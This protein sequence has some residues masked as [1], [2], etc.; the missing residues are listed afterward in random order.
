M[1]RKIGRGHTTVRDGKIIVYDTTVLEL[2]EDGE[3]AILRAGKWRTQFTCRRIN[4]A[5]DQFNFTFRVCLRKGSMF[6]YNYRTNEEWDF[7]D[8]IAAHKI[9]DIVDV[10]EPPE[11]PPFCNR[12]NAWS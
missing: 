10:P 8:G 12:G 1:K 6:L 7:V 9:D 3:V 5:L 2:V 4:E 11:P